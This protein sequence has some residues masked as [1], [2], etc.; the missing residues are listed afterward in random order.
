MGVA[1][2]AVLAIRV[3]FVQITSVSARPIVPLN[4]VVTMDAAAHVVIVMSVLLALIS[5]V[6]AR[7]TARTRAVATT[8]AG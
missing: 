5:A 6:S 8:D 3:P 4:S 7:P 1:N 2:P